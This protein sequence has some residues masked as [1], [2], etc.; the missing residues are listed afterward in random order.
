MKSII[1]LLQS[2]AG[3][4]LLALLWPTGLVHAEAAASGNATHEQADN[5]VV[6]APLTTENAYAL[7]F[8][9]TEQ[10]RLRAALS[11]DETDIDARFFVN[12][13]VDE[14]S[15]QFSMNTAL[16][17]WADLDTVPAADQPTSLREIHDS[18]SSPLWLDIYSLQ[19]QYTG[20]G[21]LHRARLGRVVV[22]HGLPRNIDGGELELKLL[23]H[24]LGLFAY[25]GRSVHFFE[26]ETGLFE[27]WVAAVGLHSRPM[28]NLL[29]EV[30]AEL[31]GATR[32]VCARGHG[33]VMRR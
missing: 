1:Q 30:E 15:G 19:A 29:V 28:H 14:R 17:I 21:F 26:A 4:L 12:A 22:D 18:Q 3:F 24:W 20:H 27:D 31:H 10:A 6:D 33:A 23:S 5:S 32:P 13:D 25:G 11:P 7:H 2:R 8:V 16:G 9:S